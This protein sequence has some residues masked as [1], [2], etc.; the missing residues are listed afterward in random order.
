METEFDLILESVVELSM[1]SDEWEKYVR[2]MLNPVAGRRLKQSST[3]F[4]FFI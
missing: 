4:C 2:R 3:Y 1:E